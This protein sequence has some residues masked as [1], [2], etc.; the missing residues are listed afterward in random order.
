MQFTKKT[1]SGSFQLGC[2]KVQLDCN[3]VFVVFENSLERFVIGLCHALGAEKQ[4]KKKD[5]GTSFHGKEGV[6]VFLR[7]EY[8]GMHFEKS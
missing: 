4:K 8:F 7:K 5:G 2:V 6:G 1:H 3:S